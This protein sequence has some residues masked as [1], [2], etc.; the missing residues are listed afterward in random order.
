LTF[1]NEIA[2]FAD[3]MSS[4]PLE[5]GH[6]AA[7][8]PRMED[9]LARE[10]G[11]LLEDVKKALDRDFDG[12]ARSAECLAA[13]LASKFDRGNQ[14]SPARGGLA[15]WQRRKIQS[16]IE[17]G[18]E[19]ALTIEQLARLVSL[20]PSYFCRAFKESFGDPP[21]AYVIKMRV[22]RARTLMR[23]TSES[24]SQIAVACGLADQAHLCRCFRQVTGMTP[25]AWRRSH[26]VGPQPAGSPGESHHVM[27]I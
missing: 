7:R 1:L 2:L 8:S 19:G 18:L 12:A 23:T 13:L 9:H 5:H 25:G 11:K 24:L 17:H 15:P 10:I 16:H 14:T 4:I 22:E 3:G 6:P 20:S 27:S 26:A 21:H